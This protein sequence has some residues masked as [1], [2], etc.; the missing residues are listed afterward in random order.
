MQAG[1]HRDELLT[2]KLRYKAPDGDDSRLITTRMT[3]RVQPPSST[4]GFASAVA[5]A[6]LVWRGSPERA[7][8]SLSSAAERARQYRG[9]DPDGYRAEFIRLLELARGLSRLSRR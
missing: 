1:T 7:Q 8:A 9:D 3:A 5:E 6:G 4:M 2:V